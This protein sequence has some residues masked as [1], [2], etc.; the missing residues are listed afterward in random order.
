MA[1]LALGAINQ[2]R[3]VVVVRALKGLGD[4]LCVVPA[5]RALRAAAP[6]AHVT[7]VGLSSSQALVSRY[8]KYVDE[9]LPFPGFPGIPESPVDAAGLPAFFADAQARS[10]DLALQMHGNG[11]LTNPFTVMLGAKATAG[12]C[13]PGAYCP[14]P[15][16]FLAL[17]ESDHEVRRWLRLLNHLGVPSF[18]EE[19]EFPLH[20]SD[21]AALRSVPE[22]GALSG[23]KFVAVHAG[24]TE[25]ARRWSPE[26]F[27]AAAD[28]FARD[29]YRVVLTG[30]AEEAPIAEQV[31]SRMRYSALNLAG[32][33]NLG[34]M[35]ALLSRASLLVSND[36][37]V[38]H[39]AAALRVPSVIVFIASDPFRWAPLDHELHRVVG[40]DGLSPDEVGTDAVLREAY[41]LLKKRARTKQATADSAAV[42]AVHV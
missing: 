3:R 11:A 26:H 9:L 40:R 18:G 2:W 35:A 27:A 8:S 25:P 12:Y 4:F 10:F 41:R 13:A 21:W 20:E 24:A 19:L 6:Q 42:E 16:R 37:G 28:F 17:N 34:A 29:G 23:S 38:S 33:T 30:T 15:E 5:L 22:A 32:R 7:L 39:L 36:T 1:E 14:D 31:A